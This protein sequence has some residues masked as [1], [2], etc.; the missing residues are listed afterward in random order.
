[1]C[2]TAASQF[3]TAGASSTKPSSASSSVTLSTNEVWN[4]YC[5]KAKKTAEVEQLCANNKKRT[6]ILD[7]LRAGGQDAEARKGLLEQLKL[8]PPPAYATTQALY[9]DFCKV[10]E[11]GEKPTCMR[12]KASQASNNMRNWYC[13]TTSGSTGDWCKRQAVLSRMQKIPLITDPK[14][15]ADKAQYEERKKLAAEYTDYSRPLV[16]GGPSKASAIAKEIV[17]AKKLYCEQARSI[18]ATYHSLPLTLLT[19]YLL[20][21]LPCSQEST[22]TLAYCKSPSI[23][24]TTPTLRRLTPSTGLRTAFPSLKGLPSKTAG[25]AGLKVADKHN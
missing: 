17:A 13:A 21:S 7:Q 18:P 22:K 23:M 4:W 12:I 8:A 14:T 20:C 9:T 2:S 10:A 16:G 5:A 1:M 6:G 15:D 24:P 11:N 19:F 25:G 3:K